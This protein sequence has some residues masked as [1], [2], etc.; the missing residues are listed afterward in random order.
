MTRVYLAEVSRYDGRIDKLKEGIPE[1][2]LSHVSKYKDEHDIQASLLGWNIFLIELEKKKIEFNPK[3][4]SFN[5]FGKPYYKGMYFNISHSKDI[6]AFCVSDSEV[7]IDIEAI[8]DR[9][10]DLLAERYL[11][12][13]ETEEYQKSIENKAESFL[14]L[15]T[16]KE[17]FHKHVGDGINL[18]S[19][20]N[21]VPYGDIYTIYLTDK[22]DL[23]YYLSVD[24]IDNEKVLVDVL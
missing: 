10:Y 20:K 15:W 7:G 8:T 21:D 17:A 16:K 4:L 3:D 11:G 14:R 9:N 24:C 6:V 2:I 1:C 13:K 12:I 18:D 19:I 5:E 23:G 22:N